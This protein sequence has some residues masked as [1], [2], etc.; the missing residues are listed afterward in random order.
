MIQV[1]NRAFDII[2]FLAKDRNR[3]FGLG[4]IA[5]N[6]GL[7]H[8]TCANII[9][10]MI[11]REYIE[12]VGKRG[13]YLLGSRAYFLQEFSPIRKEL[14]KISVEYMKNLSAKLNEGVILTVIQ[15]NKRLILHDERSKH[16]LQVINPKEKDLYRS[17]TGRLLLAFSAKTEQDAF[18]KKY[19]LP[20]NQSWPEIDN[21]KSLFRHLNSIKKNQIAIQVSSANIVGIA[22]PVFRN[23]IAVA[24]L[25]IYLPKTRFT[26]A[27]QDLLF[28]E[29]YLTA[30]Y[31]SK[32]L[33]MKTLS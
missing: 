32:G 8:G 26:K 14:I 7:N 23:N 9:K 25:G 21:E 29:L 15:N 4:E 27:M 20:D 12:Q 18:I 28:K 17:S 3:E 10:T 16:E 33:E 6:L 5:D 19:G 1:L 31:I 2:E 22:V 13:K 11:S 24:C 30:E